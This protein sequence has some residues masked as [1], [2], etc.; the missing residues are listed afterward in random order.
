MLDVGLPGISGYEI[1]Y[2]LRAEL[3]DVFPIV[4]I[5]GVR[6]EPLD[7]RVGIMLGADEYLVKPFEP[8]RLL[9]VVT[10]L[11]R[12]R[13]RARESAR[14]TAR[15]LQVMTLLHRG[16]PRKAIA[17][18]L[19]ISPKTVGSHVERVMSKLGAR[20][21]SEAVATAVELGLLPHAPTAIDSAT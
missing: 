18:R 16:A 17:G 15:E 21:Q 14:L 2:Q 5:S 6:T 8:A 7:R 9:A 4:F 3:G 11:L 10:S 1:C 13:S 12:R 19:G 20:T